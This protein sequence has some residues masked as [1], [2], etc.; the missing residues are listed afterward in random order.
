MLLLFMVCSWSLMQIPCFNF[1][2]PQ[3]IA[4]LFC[5]THKTVAMGVPLINTLFEHS[6]SLGLYTLPLLMYHPI[7]LL[8]GSLLVPSLQG[9]SVKQARLVTGTHND[10]DEHLTDTARRIQSPT[11]MSVM[12]SPLATADEEMWELTKTAAP[13][14]AVEEPEVKS[15][16]ESEQVLGQ[17]NEW[18]RVDNETEVESQCGGEG[19][20]S[21]NGSD[22]W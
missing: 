6:E 17:L 11:M 19:H 3:R 8:I 12:L 1:S 15:E 7:Q 9:A 16:S 22:L 2:L 21:F 20:N 10:S 5:S 4:G 13:N 18:V 14:C